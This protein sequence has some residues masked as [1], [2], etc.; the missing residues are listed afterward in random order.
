MEPLYQTSTR[1]DSDHSGVCFVES[2][3]T[4]QLRTRGETTIK[5]NVAKSNANAW[6]D[7]NKYQCRKIMESVLNYE[8]VDNTGFVA[9]RTPEN[10]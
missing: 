6:R 9:R 7:H 3:Q 8:A 1:K 10:L 4:T 5:T 2:E